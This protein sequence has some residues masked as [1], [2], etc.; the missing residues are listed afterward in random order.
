[1]SYIAN[2]RI[3]FEH[4][5]VF[6]A[7]YITRVRD[8]R[9]FVV[10]NAWIIMDIERK[11]KR[12]KRIVASFLSYTIVYAY[13][14]G[15]VHVFTFKHETWMN[16]VLNGHSIRCFIMDPTASVSELYDQWIE[17][18]KMFKKVDIV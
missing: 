15:T 18:L 2:L 14:Q 6:C 11:R 13:V 10:L 3:L 9:V 12:K 1:M 17:T 7:F 16:K 8:K 5:L 4:V